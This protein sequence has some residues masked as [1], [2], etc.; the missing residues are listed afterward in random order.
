MLVFGSVIFLLFMVSH[1]R[2]HFLVGLLETFFYPF[3]FSFGAQVSVSRG[4]RISQKQR[5]IS[6][7]I[8]GSI[9]Q[10]TKTDTT[11]GRKLYHYSR[12]HIEVL[13]F[14]PRKHTNGWFSF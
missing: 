14:R 8:F 4:K 7:A 5:W 6:L 3:S 2:L 1:V 13:F 9:G 12:C 11:H 10:D